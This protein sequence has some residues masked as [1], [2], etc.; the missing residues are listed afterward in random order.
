MAGAESPLGSSMYMHSCCLIRLPSRLTKLHEARM[1]ELLQEELGG[2]PWVTA[3]VSGEGGATCGALAVE[4]TQ[5]GQF[6]AILRQAAAVRGLER[7]RGGGCGGVLGVEVGIG[8]QGVA[9]CC[10]LEGVE[11]VRTVRID[12][13]EDHCR[14]GA[15]LVSPGVGGMEHNDLGD[16]GTCWQSVELVGFHW[17]AVP[18]WGPAL[19]I[20]DGVTVSSG[21]EHLKACLVVDDIGADLGS[22]EA[23]GQVAATQAAR[24]LFSG[25]SSNDRHQQGKWSARA[26][27]RDVGGKLC[28]LGETERTGE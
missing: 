11:G 19:C 2:L 17:A 28:T 20:P 10:K 9:A 27:V 1:G 24:S 5:H 21:V 12:V 14:D 7:H 18:C 3:E 4:T 15:K 23:G 22:G 25:S 6:G 13:G 16:E 26:C 8:V